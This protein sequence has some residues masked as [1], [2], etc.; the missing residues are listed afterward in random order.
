M[1]ELIC[2][3]LNCIH[4]IIEIDTCELETIILGCSGICIEVQ[5]QADQEEELIPAKIEEVKELQLSV[6]SSKITVVIIYNSAQSPEMRD[7]KLELQGLVEVRTLRLKLLKHR[8]TIR[9]SK[10]ASLALKKL[11]F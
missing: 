1:T 7:L 3:N 10:T 8:V 11:D 9:G 6:K 4:N 5:S 2:R